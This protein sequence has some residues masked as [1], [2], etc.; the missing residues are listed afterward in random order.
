MYIAVGIGAAL[1]VITGVVIAIIFMCKKKKKICAK[2][3]INGG[4]HVKTLPY[5]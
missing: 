5:F 1:I 2:Q 3:T 4:N